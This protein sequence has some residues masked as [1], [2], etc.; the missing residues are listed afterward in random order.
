MRHKHIS[1][2]KLGDQSAVVK[3]V[4]TNFSPDDKSVW[5]KI[6]AWQ[7]SLYE[8]TKCFVTSERNISFVIIFEFEYE[9]S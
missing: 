3:M 6:A 2:G 9:E 4:M 8:Q 5:M 7:K 1:Y